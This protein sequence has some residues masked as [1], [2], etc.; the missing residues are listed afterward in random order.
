MIPI[1]EDK[2]IFVNI[3]Y[4]FFENNNYISKKYISFIEVPKRFQLNNDPG[5]NFLESPSDK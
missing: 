5:N 3:N 2:K 4:K 1:K